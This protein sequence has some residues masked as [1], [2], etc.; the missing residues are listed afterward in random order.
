[1]MTG[2]TAKKNDFWTVEAP[3]IDVTTL[4]A[5]TDDAPPVVEVETVTKPLL[6]LSAATVGVG[7]T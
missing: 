4:A 2:T 1:M 7:F 3:P 5:A 6:V